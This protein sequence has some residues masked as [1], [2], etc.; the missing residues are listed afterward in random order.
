MLTSSRKQDEENDKQ[1]HQSS[2]TNRDDASSSGSSSSSSTASSSYI[3]WNRASTW[4]QA[5]L[6]LKDSQ[7]NSLW[8]ERLADA[9]SSQTKDHDLTVSLYQRA[10]AYEDPS[11]LCHRGLGQTHYSQSRIA[12]AIAQVE[13]ALKEAE[14]ESATPKPEVKDIVELHLLLGKYAYEA[15]NM[16]SAEEHYLLACKSEDAEQA[17]QAQLGHFKA[18]LSSPDAEKRRQ[19]LKSALAEEDGEGRMVKLLKMLARDSDHD[20]FISNMFTMAKEDPYLLKAILDAM[21]TATAKPGALEDRTAETIVQS[22]RF[23]EHEARGVL[24]YDLGVAAYRYKV[25]LDDT[26]PVRKALRLW[27]ETRDELANVGGRNASVARSNATSA[28]ANHYFQSMLDEGHLDHLNELAKLAE[29]DAD[30]YNNDP[31]GL[32]GAL[33]A[34][35]GE[36][37]KARAVLGQQVRQALQIL[38]DDTPENDAFGFALLQRAMEKYQDFE[39]SAV[40]LSLLGQP[41]LVTN[42]LYFEAE[43][44]VE[45]D[46]EDKQRVLEIVTKLAEE[47]TQVAKIQVPDIAMQLRRIEVAN[48]HVDFLVAAAQTKTKTKPEADGDSGGEAEKPNAPEPATGIAHRLLQSR[49]SRLKESHTPELEIGTIQLQCQCDGRI[50]DGKQCENM[51]DFGRGFYHCIY[52]WNRDF[53]WD[54]LIRLRDPGSDMITLCSAKHRWLRIPPH[55]E[56]VYVGTRAKSVRMPSS[57]KA[58]D[59]DEQVLV[60][61][62]AED[63]KGEEITVEAWKERVAREWDISL[64]EIR[65]GMPRLATPEGQEGDQGEKGGIIEG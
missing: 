14:R 51:A 2:D 8:Y 34:L 38:S 17:L 44:I 16:P 45:S 18:K 10:I 12:E 5:I 61:C 19:F 1:P 55:G 54:C 29:D 43:D 48:A 50:L 63:G 7:L 62:Y 11:W 36:K 21:R 59:G 30:V 22:D 26:E 25:L 64:K 28:L 65:D 33:H 9:S 3:D 39:N 24:L 23:A 60:A 13:L 4:C 31:V 35:R 49:L 27:T 6:E 46:G 20:A 41:D 32:L 53:C 52:C 58:V 56:D 57:V 15:D 37:E 40:A 47:T 42:S